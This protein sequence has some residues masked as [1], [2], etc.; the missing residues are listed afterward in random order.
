MYE[1]LNH[2]KRLTKVSPELEKE[3]ISRSIPIKVS[4]GAYLHKAD[5]ICKNTYWIQQGLLR[6]FYLKDGKEITDL[7]RFDNR[8][9]I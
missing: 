2:F 3:L 5:G 4:K 6:T 7:G 1:F 8:R 9:I